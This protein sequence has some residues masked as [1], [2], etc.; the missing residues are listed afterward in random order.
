MI[1]YSIS[2]YLRQSKLDRTFMGFPSYRETD[3]IGPFTLRGPGDLDIPYA[4][5]ENM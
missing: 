4:G 3:Q 2:R 5:I 1:R